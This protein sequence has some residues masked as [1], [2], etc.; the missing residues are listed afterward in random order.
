MAVQHIAPQWQRRT[1]LKGAGLGVLAASGLTALQPLGPQSWAAGERTRFVFTWNAPDILDPHV[2]YDVGAAAF[3]LN[4]YDNLLRYHGNPPEIV[5]WLAETHEVTD[6]GRKWTFHLRRDATFH[7]GSA[8]TAEAV[9]F[10]FARLLTLSKGPS[11]IFKRMGLTPEAIR[12]LDPHTI[13][14]QLA[15]P[16]GPFRMAMPIVSIVNPTLIKA[17]EQNGDW[18]EPWL[19]Q[20]EA[21]SGAYRLVKFD[22]ATGFLMERFP[23]FWGGWRDKHV[24]EAEI[25]VIREQSSRTLALM[26]GDVHMIETLLGADQLEK[27]EKHPRIKVTPYESMR[28]FVIRMHNQRPPFTDINVRKAF[29]YAFN[30]KS[31]IEDLMK[32][33]VV[34]N[35]V[36]IPRPLWG[37]PTDLP[38]YEY[39]LD[40]A[41]EYLAKATVKITRPIEVHVQAPLEPTVQA[42][43]LFQSDLAKLGIELKIVKSMFPTIVASTKTVE[44]TPDMWIHWISTYFVDPENWIGEMYDSANGGTWKASSWYKNSQVD[45]LLGRARSILAQEERAKLYQEACRLVVE[46]A[47]DLWVYN[48]IEYVPLAKNVQGFQFSLVGSGQEFWPLYFDPRA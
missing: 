11:A 4:L 28:F 18:A 25:R 45:A 34:R 32:G 22:Q 24:D 21:G 9:S 38:G 20:N 12:V 37:Y 23:G 35:P 27:L 14:F 44:S 13:E 15:Q 41:K 3:N 33:R 46:D 42:A 36:P 26:K 31:F 47:P 29:S 7:D 39:D 6:D 19:A 2:K 17:H 10:S 1:F 30:Y 40:K 16:F 5:P 48:T 43:L 8:L